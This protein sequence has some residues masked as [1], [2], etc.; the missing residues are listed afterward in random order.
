[1]EQ[2]YAFE[3]DVLVR[4]QIRPFRTEW[5]IAAPELMIAGT[6]DFVGKKPDGKYVLV[7]WKRSLKLPKSIFNHFGKTAK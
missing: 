1:M 6:I 5:Q 3:K 4:N 7:D 2:L